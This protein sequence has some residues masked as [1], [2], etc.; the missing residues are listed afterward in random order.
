MEK[1]ELKKQITMG[2]VLIIIGI[3]LFLKDFIADKREKVF[4]SMNLELTELLAN[5]ADEE[6]IEE[7]TSREEPQEEVITNNMAQ[8]LVKPKEEVKT[9]ETY[10]VQRT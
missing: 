1:K 2:V 5:I 10:V 3:S 9:Y 6:V 4:S 7:N 8:A